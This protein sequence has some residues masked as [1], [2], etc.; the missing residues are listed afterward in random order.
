M[1]ISVRDAVSVLVGG[2]LG[3]IA[4]SLGSGL[5]SSHGSALNARQLLLVNLLTDLL[6]SLALSVRP[7]AH[8]DPEALLSEGPDRSLAGA[9]TR[10]V[11]VRAF[12][13]GASAGGAW[14]V[15]RSTGTRAHASTVGLVALV[16]TQ[17]GQT[18]LVGWRSPLVLAGSAA[19]AGV[20][21]AIVQT[22][23]LSHFFGCRPLG[24]LGW[25]TALSAAA[26]GTLASSALPRLLPPSFGS[27]P[28]ARDQR[29][30]AAARHQP[31]QTPAPT[32]RQTHLQPRKEL[33]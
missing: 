22:P 10:D 8:H 26:A 6:P 7:P 3:E 20:L 2:N 27:E 18:A 12:A 33:I 29:A 23:G 1:W 30:T 13:T 9:L 21:S 28:A 11:A 31:A 16:G 5:A 19:S 14:V 15:A 24:P 17:L 4:Y 25:S 32:T